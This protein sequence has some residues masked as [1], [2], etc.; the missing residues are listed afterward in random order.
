MD[1]IKE[2]WRLGNMAYDRQTWSQIYE[3]LAYE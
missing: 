1:S 2:E 3:N